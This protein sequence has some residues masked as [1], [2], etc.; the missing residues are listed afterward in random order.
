[1]CE[2]PRQKGKKLS[3]VKVE[4][5]HPMP[6]YL[7]TVNDDEKIVGRKVDNDEDTSRDTPGKETLGEKEPC[8]ECYASSESDDTH[9]DKK[10][11]HEE[12]EEIAEVLE[13]DNCQDED[14][15]TCFPQ[16]QKYSA[17]SSVSSRPLVST[18]EEQ[19]RQT[20]RMSRKPLQSTG[21]T[22]TLKERMKAFH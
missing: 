1:M 22:I 13:E 2:S 5:E 17:I 18:W 15:S 12:G 7:E 8:T 21:S 19:R 6:N 4:K 9:D 3:L 10:G 11:F 16:V 14:S 20:A